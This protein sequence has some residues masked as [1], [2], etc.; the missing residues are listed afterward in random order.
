MKHQ[1]QPCEMKYNQCNESMW[2]YQASISM[3]RKGREK[4]RKKKRGNINV[5]ETLWQPAMAVAGK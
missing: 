3:T 2:Q 1:H 4:K 5:T